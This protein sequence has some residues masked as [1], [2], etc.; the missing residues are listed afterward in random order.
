MASVIANKP[1][2]AS[3]TMT[4]KSDTNRFRWLIVQVL[5]VGNLNIW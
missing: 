2:N 3:K 4:Y 1:C 5:I